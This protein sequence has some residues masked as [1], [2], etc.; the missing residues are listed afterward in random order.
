MP[1]HP[2]IDFVGQA[3]MYK[4]AGDEEAGLGD[5]L[6]IGKRD[7]QDAHGELRK[8]I[9]RHGMSLNCANRQW[10]RMVPLPASIAVSKRV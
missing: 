5:I 8:K 6:R 2:V 7:R 1:S 9:E 10:P 3:S 4:L